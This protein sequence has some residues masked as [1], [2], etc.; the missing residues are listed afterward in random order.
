MATQSEVVK[1]REQHDAAHD[2]K[3]ET[4]NTLR[5]VEVDPSREVSKKRQ[6]L[7]DLFT[8]VRPSIH[9]LA[10]LIFSLWIWLLITELRVVCQRLCP[11]Q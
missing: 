5:A 4:D 11:H 2:W 10:L 1:V 8:I 6:S 3:I 7:S 9:T